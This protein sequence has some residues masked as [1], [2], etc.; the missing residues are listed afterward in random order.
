MIRLQRLALLLVTLFACSLATFAK[1][2]WIEVRSQNFYL[3]GNAS[4]KDIR[5]VA[6]KLEQFRETFRLV[7]KGL[8][9]KSSTPTNVIVFKSDSSYKQFKPKRADGK[10]DTMVA[11]YFQ[12]GDDVNYITLSTE[13]DD[14]ET[15]STI[16][17]EYVHSIV[18]TNFGKSD[19][20]A[21]FNEG[22]AEYFSTFAV[23][24]SGTK[25]KLG[26]PLGRHLYLLSQS[27][28]IPLATLFALSNEQMSNSG[29][30]SRS[31]FYA[32]SWVLV[33]YLLR[34]GKIESLGK[35]LD[36]VVKG[37]PNETAFQ[38]AFQ[39]S[40]T[41][42]ENDLRKYVSNDKYEYQQL[43][44]AHKLV[45]DTDMTVSLLGDA[46]M[47]TYLGDLLTHIQR[48]D[49]AEPFLRTAIQMDP[50]SS[51]ANTTLGTV[52]MRQRKFDE[53]R[54]FLELAIADDVSNAKAYYNYAFLL[55]REGSDE[56]GFAKPFSKDAAAKMRTA[57]KK[58][59]A[60][61]PDFTPSYELLAYVS[62][63][64]NEGLDEAAAVMLSALRQQPG[65]Q[66]YILRLADIY[67]RLGKYAEA[68]VA[69]EKVR[70]TT[71]DAGLRSRAAEMADYL[72]KREEFDKQR[73]AIKN[74]SGETSRSSGPPVIRSISDRPLT[75]A[76]LAKV[77]ADVTLR[78]INS[79]L[80]KPLKG[81][82]RVIG[83][84]Q[85]ID[86]KK[87]IIYTIKT[88]TE[89]FALTSADFQRLELNVFIKEADNVSVGCDSD[90]SPFNAMVT[91]KSSTSPK[92]NSRGELVALEFV[93][94]DFRLMTEDEMK[95]PPPRIVAVE[96][97]DD[98]GI[99]RDP[100]PTAEEI[101]KMRRAEVLQSLKNALREPGEGEKRV[102]AFLDGIECTSK[103]QY[104]K[105]HA[106]S[107]PLRLITSQEI[108]PKI[109]LFTPD[110]E[111]VRF[112]CNTKPIEY[113]VVLVYKD[114]PDAKA[115]VAGTVIELDFVPKSF[116]LN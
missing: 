35:F 76:E 77:K 49:D 87:G 116:V 57:L 93:T 61:K 91:Y 27:Q 111:G 43:T 83:S 96:T 3:I 62:V 109:R 52:K 25:A 82:T 2:Q 92:L 80:H 36:L 44:F 101:E 28:F 114:A 115:K 13:G 1:D 37:E 29:D 6:T 98:K 66:A 32:E 22:L 106:D 95:Q 63:V 64:T 41:S 94:P 97:V 7:F 68:R 71:D 21:W 15:F 110:L 90:L 79:M 107:G 42:M 55:S 30:H 73:A 103:A 104:F 113:P 39:T 69:I 47:N 70:K 20:P 100:I 51:M 108:V 89:S 19:V 99:A 78:S 81:E 88:P 4:E 105:F 85:K 46:S 38:T 16:F 40:Y 9:L 12:S 48:E 31:I 17:H 86:C 74:E 59:I 84:V 65:N 5:S 26:V 56:F 45:N 102:Y 10:I 23:D 72:D 60:L 112:G 54:Q 11:G 53:A 18:N 33:H 75:A 50:R 8:S 67:S 58:A 34:T 14:S 24:S